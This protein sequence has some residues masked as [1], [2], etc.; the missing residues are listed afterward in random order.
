MGWFYLKSLEKA[1]VVQSAVL[2]TSLVVME[3]LNPFP[4]TEAMRLVKHV[5]F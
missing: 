5:L 4:Y 2:E 3:A 1:Q